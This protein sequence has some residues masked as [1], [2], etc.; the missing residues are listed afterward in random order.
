[1]PYNVISPDQ[2]DNLTFYKV[3]LYGESGT[4]KT[5]AASSAPEP[6][7]LVTEANALATLNLSFRQFDHKHAAVV[8]AQGRTAMDT[9]REVFGDA[10]KGALQKQGYRTLVVDGLSDLQKLILED[11]VGVG[12]DEVSLKQWGTLTSKMRR[13]MRTLRDL[14]MNVVCTALCDSSNNEATGQRYVYPLFQ[15]KKITKEVAGY[16]NIVGY[17]F[18]RDAGASSQRWA[19]ADANGDGDLIERRIVIDGPEGVVSKGVGPIGGIQEPDIS[20]W[21]AV[22]NGEVDDDPKAN[23]G[24]TQPEAPA[25]AEAS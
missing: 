25:H 21:F 22:L 7:C 6:F 20:R 17:C 12:N 11:I 10:L 8:H 5:W 15:G 4:G 19:A 9:V 24:R 23:Q 16:F 1:M 13:V 3:L 18:K 2:L 14:D